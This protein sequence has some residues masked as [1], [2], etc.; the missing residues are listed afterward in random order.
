MKKFMMY[1]I[2]FSVLFLITIY[3]ISEVYWTHYDYE[4][5]K[6]Y[7]YNKLLEDS[8]NTVVLGSSHTKFGIILSNFEM[9]LAKDSQN[10]YYDLKLLEKYR[11]KIRKKAL[12][13]LPISIQSFYNS[14]NKEIDNGYINILRKENIKNINI[15]NYILKG[16]FSIFFPPTN[17]FRLFSS[18]NDKINK[19]YYY[20]PNLEENIR[21]IESVE[22]VES[23]LGIKKTLERNYLFKNAEQDFINLLNYIED[24]NWRYVLITTPF[25]YLYNENIEKYQPG[26]FKERIYDNIK[27]VEKKLNKKFVYLDYSHDERFENHLEY[28]F[29][30]DHLNEKGA[31]Y[32]TE[33]L[34]EDLK[35]LGYEFE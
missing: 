1:N 15:I 11:G 20:P 27:E 18:I 21:K 3:F 14:K 5:K 34:L 8:V 28:F 10:F 33:I 24:N 32:F 31:K 7:Y 23:H 35:K 19:F 26:A 4:K 17:F 2:T 30:D 12:I 9:N 16:K 22:T 6:Y 29:D 25:S 13:I